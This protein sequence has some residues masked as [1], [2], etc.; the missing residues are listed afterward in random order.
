MSPNRIIACR[1]DLKDAVAGTCQ[2][3]ASHPPNL[4]HAKR[5]VGYLLARTGEAG[6][7]G[8]VAACPESVW[9]ACVRAFQ[10]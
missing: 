4:I 2:A 6:R 1:C 3:R 7:A 5:L 8:I 10:G 9:F